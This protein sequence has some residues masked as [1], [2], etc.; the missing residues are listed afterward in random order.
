MLGQQYLS[1]QSY[2]STSGINIPSGGFQDAVTNFDGNDRVASTVGFDG[3]TTI[4][5]YDPATG[6]QAGSFVDMNG[7]GVYDPGVDRK[8]VTHAA[9]DPNL[10]DTDPSNDAGAGKISDRHDS[11]ARTESAALR[12]SWS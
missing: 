4:M 8:S 1:Q 5:L 7:N 12:R 9:R 3:S 10:T 2:P 11:P 6:Q